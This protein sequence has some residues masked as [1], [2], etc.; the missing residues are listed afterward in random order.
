MALGIVREVGNYVYLLIWLSLVM[1]K[2]FEQ[3]LRGWF[4][5]DYAQHATAFL[6]QSLKI[7][8]PNFE[9]NY[10]YKTL[11]IWQGMEYY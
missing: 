1:L 3:S 8:S 6:S 11:S 10:F 5:P 7:T 2:K 4:A 9:Y